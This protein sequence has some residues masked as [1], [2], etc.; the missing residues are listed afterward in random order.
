MLSSA[1][2]GQ[3]ASSPCARSPRISLRGALSFV[4]GAPMSAAAAQGTP[5]DLL[6]LVGSR[7]RLWAYILA[8]SKGS[9]LRAWLPGSRNIRAEGDPPFRLG[10]STAS[11]AGAVKNNVGCLDNHEG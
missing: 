10:R 6:V 8:H 4:S 1:R 2:S 5:L 9:C 3:G 7:L 11:A